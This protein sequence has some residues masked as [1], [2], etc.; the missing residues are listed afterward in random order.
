MVVVR[1]VNLHPSAVE[2]VLRRVVGIVE[3][4][5]LITTVRGLTEVEIVIETVDLHHETSICNEAETAL[6]VAFNLRIPV[7]PVPPGSL[8]RFELKSRRWIRVDADQKEPISR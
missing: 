4:W 2:S 8:P 5:V 3:Y 1:G 6:R 7:T